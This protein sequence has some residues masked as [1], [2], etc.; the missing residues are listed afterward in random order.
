[1]KLIFWIVVGGPQVLVVGFLTTWSALAL[2][3]RLPAP[4]GIRLLSAGFFGLFGCVVIVALFTANRR[5]AIVAF[6]LAFAA[7]ALWWSTIRPPVDGNWAPQFSR[8]V[9]G[10]VDGDILTL[11]GVRDFVWLSKTD[12]T[13]NWETRSYDMSKLETVDVFLSYWAGPN[14]AHFMLSFGFEGDEYLAWSIEVR[15]DASGGFSP[16]ADAFKE[17]SLIVLA[18][19]ERD[20]IGLR[21]NVEKDDVQMFRLRVSPEVA[22]SLLLKYV[23]DA[24]QLAKQPQFYNSITTN[25]T[26]SVLRMMEAVG[27]RFALD[28]RLIANGYLPDYAYDHGSI[29]TRV[30]LEELRQLGSISERAQLAGLA[31]GYS[32]AIREGVPSPVE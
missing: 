21:T 7:M 30:S 8:Q 18:T 10:K 9:T 6:V 4:E 5:R 14:M 24:N 31:E 13:E 32:T 1:M 19:D 3:Y 26:T 22:R 17:H 12:F 28:W 2:W 15:R 27:D 11:T 29:D 16:I 23:E 20:A 25:C